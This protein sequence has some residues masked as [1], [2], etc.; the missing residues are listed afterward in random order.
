[1]SK[2]L[3]NLAICEMK[4][5]GMNYQDND[6]ANYQLYRSP[7]EKS[8]ARDTYDTTVSPLRADASIY[9]SSCSMATGPCDH[10]FA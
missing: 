9:I 4:F 3:K 10:V 6:Y 2:L 5:V 1:M 8:A 7:P